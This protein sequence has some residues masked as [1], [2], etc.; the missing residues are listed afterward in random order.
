MM[1]LTAQKSK[2]HTRGLVIVGVSL[3]LLFGIAFLKGR[4]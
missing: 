2:A 4:V 1:D 3:A